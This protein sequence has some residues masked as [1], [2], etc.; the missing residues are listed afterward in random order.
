[1]NP[2]DSLRMANVQYNREM[3]KKVELVK[4][5]N[6]IIDSINLYRKSQGKNVLT[7]NPELSVM[8]R[9]WSDSLVNESLLNNYGGTGGLKI[10]HSDNPYIENCYGVPY[11][12]MGKIKDNFF[13]T[14]R[15]MSS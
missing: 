2:L 13:N 8:A 6:S 7:Y 1:M 5:E 15:Y 9:D 10:Y 11:P 12:T 14:K 4:I 3:I